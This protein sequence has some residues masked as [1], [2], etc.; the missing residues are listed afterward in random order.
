MRIKTF[1]KARYGMNLT[2]GPIFKTLLVFTIPVILTNFL[3]Q[4]Y[5]TLGSVIVGNFAGKTA[6]AA[7]GA[8]TSLTNILL[9]FFIGLSVGAT[10]TC[11]K[12]FGAGDREGLDKATHT[13]I[14]TAL[15]SGVILAFL[16]FFFSKPLLILIDTPANVLGLSTAYMRIYFLGSPFLMLYNFGSGILRAGGDTQR[17]LYILSASGL[18]NIAVSLLCVCV[19][20]LSVVG[21]AIGTVSSQVFSS[22]MVMSILLKSERVF[23][24]RIK[25]IKLH[26]EPFLDILRVGVPSGINSM[27]FSFANLFLQSNINTYEDAYIAGS[28]A[29]T[30]VENFI[31]LA[32]NAIEQAMVSC[33]GQNYGAKKY[34][35]IDKVVLTSMLMG[36]VVTVFL[37]LI[38]LWKTELLLS[39]FNKDGEVIKAGVIRLGIVGKTCL[40]YLP[41]VLIPGA[42]KGMERSTLP[43]VLNIIFVCATRVLWILFIYPISPS[44]E[45]IF[46]CFPVSWL[47]ATLAQFT[48]YICVRVQINNKIKK[49]ELLEEGL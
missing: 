15:L 16:G 47:L 18:I 21:A 5:I 41:N 17:P 31:F 27:L 19:F 1:S 40:L 34:K 2:E 10:V 13:S 26:K 23:N 6:L 36:T 45:M 7:I 9:Y 11:A 49:Q 38:V 4:L 25:D 22:M 48:A 39:I 33:V 42:L 32:M 24:I 37:S 14:M 30:N 8:T 29:A 35:R 20:K 12:H 3:Q 28:A 46:L 44:F 43:T